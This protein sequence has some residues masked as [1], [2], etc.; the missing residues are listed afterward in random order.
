MF[1]FWV[2]TFS[3]GYLNFDAGSHFLYHIDDLWALCEL[4][5]IHRVDT[6][7]VLF[8]D[9]FDKFHVGIS[10]SVEFHHLDSKTTNGLME[11]YF[12]FITNVVYRDTLSESKRGVRQN[13]VVKRKDQKFMP[14]FIVKF[15]PTLEQGDTHVIFWEDVTRFDTKKNGRLTLIV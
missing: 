5:V 12:G 7:E 11:W 15:C 9:D 13:V 10:L 3:W 2:L 4:G 6:L 14:D 1:L 8:I